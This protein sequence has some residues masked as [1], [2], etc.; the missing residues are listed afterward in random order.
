MIL[1]HHVVLASP[2]RVELPLQI[3][4]LGL[5]ENLVREA[6]QVTVLESQILRVVFRV[7]H[8]TFSVNKDSHKFFHVLDFG[9]LLNRSDV[10]PVEGTSS[11]WSQTWYLH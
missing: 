4:R 1:L 7:A 6:I 2:I 10:S 5:P 9:Q 3:Q 11:L 8:K